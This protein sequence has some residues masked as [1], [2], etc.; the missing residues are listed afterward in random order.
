M[1]RFIL[2]QEIM[3]IDASVGSSTLDFLRSKGM[4]GVKEACHEGECGACM[5]L[6]GEL[7]DKN[8]EY[9]AVTSCILPL[10]EIVGKTCCNN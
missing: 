3:E 2:N 7:K 5:V 10:G 4:K 1:M 6:L 9:K 8:I